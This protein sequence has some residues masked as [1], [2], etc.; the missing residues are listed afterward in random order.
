MRLEILNNMFNFQ[1]TENNYRSM[2]KGLESYFIHWYEEQCSDRTGPIAKLNHKELL[3]IVDLL[4][5]PLMTYD[6]AKAKVPQTASA[7]KTDLEIESGL[8]LAARIWSISSIGSLKQCLSFGSNVDWN[9]GSL[10]DTL[11]AHY[12]LSSVTAGNAKIPKL[13]N[14]VNLHRIA[15]IKICWTS[16]LLD[17]LQMTDDD[18]TVHIFHHASFLKLHRRVESHVLPK[19]FIEETFNTLALLL[20][21]DNATSKKWFQQQIKELGL[22]PAAGCNGHLNT[23]SRRLENFKYWGDKISILK[24]AFDDSEPKTVS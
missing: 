13:F 18:K 6:I 22:D 2:E 11:D 24:Q 14:A 3:E 20:P 9:S 7:L 12:S 21:Q 17:H 5:D 19:D 15:G 4:K 1:M 23:S 10:K 16:N 8:V